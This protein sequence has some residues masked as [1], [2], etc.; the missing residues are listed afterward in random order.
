MTTRITCSK[1]FFVGK[2]SSTIDVISMQTSNAS[3]ALMGFIKNNQKTLVK[4]I[5][6]ND[7]VDLIG[8]SLIYCPPGLLNVFCDAFH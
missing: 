3:W 2:S 8:D 1:V 4:S 6:F 5:E 7:V